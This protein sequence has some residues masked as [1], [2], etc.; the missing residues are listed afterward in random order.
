MAGGGV[1]VV[2]GVPRGVYDPAATALVR[3][4]HE[5]ALG[6]VVAVPGGSACEGFPLYEGPPFTG[7]W[8]R[9]HPV[10]VG[11]RLHT[12]TFRPDPVRM[13]RAGVTAMQT[14]ALAVLANPSPFAPLSRYHGRGAVAEH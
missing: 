4:A 1:I 2:S 14:A 6:A 9:P 8:V 3:L 10:G 11:G 13:S 5:A 12:G 7:T